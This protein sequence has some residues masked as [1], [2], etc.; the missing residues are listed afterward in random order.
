M[1]KLLS[2]IAILFGA[3]C[4]PMNI[5]AATFNSAQGAGPKYASAPARE[6]Q[7]AFL[8]KHGLDV[9][10]LQE[11]DYMAARSGYVFTALETLGLN[12]AVLDGGH[13]DEAVTLTYATD[14][15]TLVFGEALPF[16]T[17]TEGGGHYGL[18][19]FIGAEYPVKSVVRVKYEGPTDEQR[20]ALIVRA[21]FFTVINTHLSVYGQYPR[22][23]RANQLRQ[24]GAIIAAEP[25]NLIIMGDFNCKFEEAAEG[26]GFAFSTM[27]QGRVDLSGIDQIISNNVVNRPYGVATDTTDHGRAVFANLLFL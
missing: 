18:A 5:K 25:G 27:M 16:D 24:L 3:A 1:T 22:A 8:G 11:V 6:A 2:C 12:G 17:A 23:Y 4:S 14:R 9:V 19:T 7:A 10:A 20:I 13:Q 21:D 26:M 15:G